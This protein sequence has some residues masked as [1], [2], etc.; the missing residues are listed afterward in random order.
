[1]ENIAKDDS[2]NTK[3]EITGSIHP[4]SL[5]LWQKYKLG[6]KVKLLFKDTMISDD[7]DI[8][9]TRDYNTYVR[10]MD[11]I[12]ELKYVET[13]PYVR[14]GRIGDIGCAVGSWIKLACRDDR[15]RESDFY[16][17]EVAR[18]L[19][20]ICHQRKHNGEFVN[21]F[22]F[23]SQ[24]NAVTGLVFDAN[25]MNTIHTSSL[26]HEIESYG[27]R[28]ELLQF[29]RNRYQELTNGGVWINRDVVGPE[30]KNKIIFMKLNKH[31]GRNDDYHESFGV[32]EE[33]RDY[34]KG[35]STYGRFLRFAADFRANEGFRLSFKEITITDESYVE[36]SLKDACEFMSRK[37]YI[38]NW[39]SEMHETFCFCNFKEWK[40]HLE[41]SG[42][43]VLPE[44]KAYSND[45]IVENRF[46]NKV[47][48][49]EMTPSGLKRIDYPVTNM[50]LLAEK[51]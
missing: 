44:S 31:D 29:I 15:H 3:N 28:H 18:H 26:T 36:I 32:R 46:K 1:V 34:L 8:T 14:P 30:E 27:S 12:A 51:R 23:F 47:E 10:E 41:E 49:F 6:E 4:A 35:L 24:R 17:I 38:D 42:F 20:D 45:W 43:V 7:G 2:W 33:L 21:P 40:Q 13:A 5:A 50:I 16:G 39:Q 11:D 19:F 9:T 37:D 22:V 25:S 48:L